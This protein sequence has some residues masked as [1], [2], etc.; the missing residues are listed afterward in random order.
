MSKRFKWGVRS[1]AAILGLAITAG[2]AFFVGNYVI[3]GSDQGTVGSGGTGT[4]TLPLN[5]SF[6][7]GELTPTK[8][9]PLT[10]TFNNT[11][12]R[13]I[14]EHHVKFTIAPEAS[15][16]KAEWF[17][18]KVLKTGEGESVTMWESILAGGEANLSYP[19]G[20]QNVVTAGNLEL[21][22]AMKEEASVN[23]A[24]CESTK[25]TVTGKVS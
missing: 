25:I 2:F 20:T 18:V 8:T 6:P 3:E 16:C 10:A 12:G 22:L 5:V 21:R 13:T 23:Q 7:D 15:G 4:A 1:T 24:A 17:F 19:Q 14:T 9:V 11:T